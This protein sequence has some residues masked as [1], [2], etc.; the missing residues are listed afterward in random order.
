MRSAVHACVLNTKISVFRH[1][2]VCVCCFSACHFTH[3]FLD[4]AGQATEPETLI[5]LGL[6]SEEGGQVKS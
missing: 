3:V 6:L 5:P 2:F 1:M 4:E